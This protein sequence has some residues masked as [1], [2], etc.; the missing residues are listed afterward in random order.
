MRIDAVRETL[1]WNNLLKGNVAYERGG[2]R[3]MMEDHE[4]VFNVPASKTITVLNLLGQSV[5]RPISESDEHLLL[6]V[7]YLAHRSGGD[8]ESTCF[9]CGR[10]T[11]TS[12]HRGPR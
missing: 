6:G 7:D 3:E 9:D 1:T 10:L 12:F 5:A 2:V 4:F 11:R 8:Q